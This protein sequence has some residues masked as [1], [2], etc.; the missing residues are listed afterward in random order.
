MCVCVKEDKSSCIIIPNCRMHLGVCVAFVCVRYFVGVYCYVFSGFRMLARLVLIHV[1]HNSCGGNN[2]VSLIPFATNCSSIRHQQKTEKST[3]NSLPPFAPC[4]YILLLST[5]FPFA[6]IF[7][8]ETEASGWY[9]C[10][11]VAV[12][13]FGHPNSARKC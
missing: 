9:P 2:S 5:Y 7:I 13:F 4:K 8:L 1:R 3:L 11:A 6:G 10:L 12:Y